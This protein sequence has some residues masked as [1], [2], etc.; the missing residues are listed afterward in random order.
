[1]N[2]L[3][4]FVT[5]ILGCVIGGVLQYRYNWFNKFIFIMDKYLR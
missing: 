2:I 3:T 1:M 4:S 5:F